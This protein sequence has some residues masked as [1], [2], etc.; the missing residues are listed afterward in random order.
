MGL[1]ELQL[2]YPRILE[3]TTIQKKYRSRDIASCANLLTPKQAPFRAL[4]YF[5]KLFKVS[6]AYFSNPAH[7]D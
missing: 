4:I 6:L 1:W 2:K 3:D 7:V 5:S